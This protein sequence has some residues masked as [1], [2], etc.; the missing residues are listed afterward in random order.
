MVERINRYQ[1]NGMVSAIL[2]IKKKGYFTTTPLYQLSTVQDMR[3]EREMEWEFIRDELLAKILSRKFLVF[4]VRL[5][6]Y[7]FPVL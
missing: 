3:L 6:L 7:Y 1:L 2:H 4:R 5:S